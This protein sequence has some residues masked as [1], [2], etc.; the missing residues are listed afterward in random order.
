MITEK[1]P[2]M[3]LFSPDGERLYL[4]T[5]ERKRFLDALN[6]ET[7]EDRMFCQVLHYT[8]CRPSEAL[9]LTPSRILIDTKDI[10]FRSLKKR[11][12]DGKGRVKQPEYR[13]VPVPANLIDI[14]DLV[15]D[16]RRL[17]RRQ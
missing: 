5:Q 12:I 17:Y 7:R 6:E 1:S 11:K 15:F 16:I 9:E 14:F 13:T 3:R 2:E 8:G 4:T 10:V